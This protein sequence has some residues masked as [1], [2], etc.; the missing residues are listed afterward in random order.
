MIVMASSRQL[1]F[2]GLS[3]LQL[4]VPKYRFPP[5]YQEASRLTYYSSF[6]NSIEVNSS[7]YKLPLPATGA[8]WASTVPENFRFTYKLWNQITHKKEFIF[9]DGDVQKFL[10]AI[11]TVGSKRGCILIQLPPSSGKENFS[12][13]LRLLSVIKESEIGQTW[14]L[15]VEFR[16]SSWYD[17]SVYEMLDSFN[18][19]LVIHDIA[20]SATPMLHPNHEIVY[21]RFHGP[22][23][24]YRDSYP[25]SFL[26][27]YA[28]YVKEWMALNK[29]VYVY[30]NN[31]RGDAFRN[32][33]SFN[34]IINNKRQMEYQ[35]K[36]V[37]K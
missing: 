14:N 30:F 19:A 36:T 31:T 3:G 24:N 25:E 34:E 9:S 15:A 20:K 6:F 1:Y 12:Q 5:E 10:A 28:G 35:D 13:L 21:V 29:T 2:S 27:E 17:E 4:P 26:Q 8:K 37:E 23:G 33:E 32:L 16:N 22:F 18:A 11:S 7:F